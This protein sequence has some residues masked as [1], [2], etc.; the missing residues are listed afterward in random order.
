MKTK[1]LSETQPEKL[2]WA[3]LRKSTG[4]QITGLRFDQVQF[5]VSIVPPENFEDWMAWHEG[6]AEWKS[7]SHFKI[8]IKDMEGNPIFVPPIPPSAENLPHNM[9]VDMRANSRFLKEFKVEISSPVGKRFK[10]KTVNI[11][12]NG[13]LLATSVPE[14]LG[15]NFS[16][17]ITTESGNTL[18]IFC[19]LIKTDP[20]RSRV[21]FMD[22][23]RPHVLLSWLVDSKVR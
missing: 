9:Q 16:C 22:V 23:S 15:R 1:S 21:K 11:S 4:K 12:A 10:T 14:E 8:L 6:L 7:L 19:S 5:I 17:L 20:T 13:M 18:N 2:F 3:L